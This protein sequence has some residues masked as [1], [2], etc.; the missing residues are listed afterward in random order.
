MIE[1]KFKYVK[2][3]FKGQRR[4]QRNYKKIRGFTEIENLKLNSYVRIWN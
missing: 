4:I 2:M 1:G 3:N